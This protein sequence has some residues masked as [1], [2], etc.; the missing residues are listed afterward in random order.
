MRELLDIAG[1]WHAARMLKNYCL[2]DKT[3]DTVLDDYFGRLFADR[4]AEDRLT[5]AILSEDQMADEASPALAEIRR[6]IRRTSDKI[7][8]TLQQYISGGT[9]SKYLQENIVTTRGGRFVVPVKLEHKNEVR[10]LVHDTSASGATVFIE[11]MAVVE[12]NNELRELESREER[13]IDRILA[14]LSALCAAHSGELALN[15]QNITELAII[16]ARA[17]L[18]FRMNAAQPQIADHPVLDLYR[19]RHPLLD[20]KRAVPVRLMLGTDFD[21]LIIT[22]PNTGGKTVTLKTAGLLTL[23][24]QSGLHIPAD[25]QS[26]VGVFTDVLAD[27]GDEQSIEQSLSTFSAH[28]VNIVRIL[29]VCGSGSL[30]LFDELGA[31]TDPVEGAALATAILEEVRGRGAL[32]AATTHYAE[33]KAYAIDTEGV[34]NAACEFDLETLRPTYRL[35]IGTPGKSNAFA[36][37]ARLGLGLS[38]IH[39]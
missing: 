16:F 10:G 28:M 33:L 21:T 23:M 39:I 13:E 22:G 6:H 30:V 25:E 32:C 7:K 1:V 17:E 4:A 26:T 18:S 8:E 31:G 38:L 12:A 11:P 27:I 15:Y 14:E 24:A 19:A 34:C 35:L 37:S 29:S 3:F 36:I 2:A 5:R 20:P 9:F